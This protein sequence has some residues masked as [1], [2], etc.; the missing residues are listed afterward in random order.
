MTTLLSGISEA[1]NAGLGFVDNCIVRRIGGRDGGSAV[2]VEVKGRGE[3]EG[4]SLV[5]VCERER[6][7]EL[8]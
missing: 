5:C 1:G 6:E 3:R 2:R 8:K 4:E 7:R